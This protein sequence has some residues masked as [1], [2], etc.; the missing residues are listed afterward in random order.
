MQTKRSLFLF[1]RFFFVSLFFSAFSLHTLAQPKEKSVKDAIWDLIV[2]ADEL[3]YTDPA[4]GRQL[5]TKAYQWAYAVR[6]TVLLAES[7]H[8]LG[9]CFYYQN[10]LD[11]AK[12]LLEFALDIFEEQGD[13]LGMSYTCFSLANVLSDHGKY[14][15]ALRLYTLSLQ[16]DIAQG[17]STSEALV[18][19]NIA[20]IHLDQQ[21][22][23]QAEE[24]YRKALSLAKLY[25]F[26]DIETN[27]L[28]GL[29][30]IM[31]YK[32]LLVEAKLFLNRGVELAQKN[33]SNLDLI[34]AYNI[35]GKVYKALDNRELAI[36]NCERALSLAKE[37]GDPYTQ[38]EVWSNYGLVLHHF[39]AYPQA[40]EKAL[41]AYTLAMDQ[42]GFYL[43]R[44]A[45]EALALT[46]ES[47][48]NYKEALEFQKVFKAYSDSLHESNINAYIMDYTL[49]SASKENSV[50]KN[51]TE[52][53]QKIIE[54]NFYMQLG[55]VVL[56]LFFILLLILAFSAAKKQSKF[57]RLLSEKNEEVSTQQGQ[58]NAIHEQL[59]EKNARLNEQNKNKDKVFS[60]LSH[61]LRE[62]FNQLIG[63]LE[64]MEEGELLDK[65]V[66]DELLTKLKESV[67]TA[68]NSVVNLLYWSKNQLSQIKTNPERF[69]VQSLL[70]NIRRSLAPTFERKGLQVSI[71][72]DPGLE[73]LADYYQIEIALRNIV[74]NAIKFSSQGGKLDISAHLQLE[75]KEVVF[76][77]K[78]QGIGL[79]EEQ[80]QQILDVSE[81][82]S[83]ASTP[84]TLNERGT[85]LGLS[86]VKD[87]LHAN[88]GYL[89]IQ[90]TLKEGSTF[91]LHVPYLL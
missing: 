14:A 23:V 44:I 15:T 28:C 48:G 52:L 58:L 19:S 41:K 45:A 11:T 60:I 51:E 86:I 83:T 72:Q 84:G 73:L 6:D 54:R 66:F 46:A 78:D 27:A 85:G 40:Y 47:K 5:A 33:K 30:H 1:A 39:K 43:K 61:D 69:R 57:N 67:Y 8:S 17:D 55:L 16:I 68:Q 90:S 12:K 87:F 79:S 13:S 82:S 42:P 81:K 2:E 7:A 56:A 38:I 75:Q 59:L 9:E 3:I 36:E 71:A 76:S 35:W 77:V 34:Q 24:K 91:K 31:V 62:P 10:Q 88:G 53:K 22:Y 25:G 74:S 37:F 65:D 29:A 63:V 20:G 50:L 70:E 32:G 26:E 21:D 89:S 49:T 64:L 4:K 80:I 18:L